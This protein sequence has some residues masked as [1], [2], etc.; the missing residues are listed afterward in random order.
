MI[1][2]SMIIGTADRLTRARRTELEPVAGEGERAGAVAVAG[3]GRQH[4]Q[5]V[6]A[7]DHAALAL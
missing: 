4:R 3:V 1:V 5:R 2:F 7:D 6:D